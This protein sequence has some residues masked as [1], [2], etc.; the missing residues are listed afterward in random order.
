[1]VRDGGKWRLRDDALRATPYDIL[2]KIGHEACGLFYNRCTT[3]TL[4]SVAHSCLTSTGCPARKA[5]NNR[6]PKVGWSKSNST[7]STRGTL[8]RWRLGRP[9]PIAVRKN[10]ARTSQKLTHQH[11]RRVQ[12]KPPGSHKPCLWFM[13]YTTV[14]RSSCYGHQKEQDLEQTTEEPAKK[15][16]DG[17]YDLI[18]RPGPD[19]HSTGQAAQVR[20]PA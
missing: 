2:N 15:K 19:K 8:A 13:V 5:G 14:D 11:S 4:A 3:S 16:A 18:G 7:R 9:K 10:P 12:L 20:T 6:C 1:M 17:Y